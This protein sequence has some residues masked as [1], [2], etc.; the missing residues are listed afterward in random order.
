MII[1]V[2]FL[3]DWLWNILAS[4]GLQNK[5]AKILFLGLDNAGKTTLLNMLK[6]NRFVTLTPT[7]QPT[8]QELTIGNIVFTTYDLG[9]HDVARRLWQDYY[10]EVDGIVYLVDAA[11]PNRFRESR[12]ELEELLKVPGLANVP[13]L[14][15]ANKIDLPT[16]VSETDFRTF[17]GLFNTSGKDTFQLHPNQR[18]IEVFMCSIQERFGYG[19]G[20]RWLSRFIK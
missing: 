4:L 19:D 13:F 10:P 11:V 9:G 3:I 16:A 6:N 12:V 2:M 1:P 8:S 20:F 18:P 17:M 14:I 15:L 5:S 7:Y